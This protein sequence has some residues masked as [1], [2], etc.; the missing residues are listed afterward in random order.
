MISNEL[1]SFRIVP[2]KLPLELKSFGSG[3]DKIL[4]GSQFS[5]CACFNLIQVDCPAGPVLFSLA[6][7]LEIWLSLSIFQIF[8][9]L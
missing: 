3:S 5:I 2:D 4:L 8:C 6:V 9:I 7:K 1:A